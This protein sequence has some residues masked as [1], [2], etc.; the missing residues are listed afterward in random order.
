M[1][2]VRDSKESEIALSFFYVNAYIMKKWK[3]LWKKSVFLCYLNLHKD[4][5]V[6]YI[7]VIENYR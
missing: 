3:T 7:M 2:F 1:I 6:D 5:Q 4:Y